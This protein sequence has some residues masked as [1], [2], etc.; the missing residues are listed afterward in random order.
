MQRNELGHVYES[1]LVRWTYLTKECY[2]N[3]LNCAKCV[4][5]DDIKPRCRKNV[6]P[7]VI[8]LVKKFGV[9]KNYNEDEEDDV[10]V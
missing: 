2:R 3:G 1:N 6:R 8:E 7:C 5:A 9:P 4:I 10:E